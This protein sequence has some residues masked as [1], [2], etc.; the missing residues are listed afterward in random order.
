MK[1]RV[2]FLQ[3]PVISRKLPGAGCTCLLVS[4]AQLLFDILLGSG[5]ERSKGSTAENEFS[6]RR[7]SR[8]RGFR[9]SSPGMRL[10]TCVPDVLPKGLNFVHGHDET[11]EAYAGTET[12]S[13][14]IEASLQMRADSVD[15]EIDGK[16]AVEVQ[17]R[18]KASVYGACRICWRV[19]WPGLR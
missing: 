2:D 17:H 5:G 7:C 14:I 4:L 11:P 9:R 10:Q 8:V 15:V 1:R 3:R 19:V 18:C 6:N 13:E 12:V 16:S